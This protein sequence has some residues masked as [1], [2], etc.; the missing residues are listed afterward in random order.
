MR[1]TKD[2]QE[3]TIHQLRAMHPNVSFAANTPAELG[4]TLI[5]EAPYVPPAEP[6]VLIPFSI[7][8]FQAHAILLIDGHL[9]TVETLVA[10]ADA[11]T[12]LAWRKAQEFLRTSPTIAAIQQQLGWTN[13]YVDDLFV[14][15]SKITA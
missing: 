5:P 6:P 15:G 1:Y 12:Q 9:E 10:Q 14:R 7:T 13:E 3:Y 2:E 8:P 11:M 4:Y